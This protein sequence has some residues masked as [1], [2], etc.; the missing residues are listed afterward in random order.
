MTIPPILVRSVGLAVVFLFGACSQNL[1]WTINPDRSG[2]FTLSMQV[3]SLKMM[4]KAINPSAE[5]NADEAAVEGLRQ[6]I[7]GTAGIEIWADPSITDTKDFTTIAITGYFPDINKINIT[8]PLP[9]SP[10][11]VLDPNTSRMSE[12]GKEW[13]LTLS[14]SPVERPSSTK[15]ATPTMSNEEEADIRRET[16]EAQAQAE[17][18]MTL[19]AKMAEEMPK[20]MGDRQEIT[21]GGKILKAEG[22]ETDGTKAWVFESLRDKIQLIMKVLHDDDVMLMIIREAKRQGVGITNIDLRKLSPDSKEVQRNAIRR[23]FPAGVGP[24][25]LTILPGKPVFDYAK[26]VADARRSPNALMKRIRER[27]PNSSIAVDKLE[28]GTAIIGVQ[29]AES[30]QI[31]SVFADSPAARAGLKEGDRIMKVDGDDVKNGAEVSAKIRIRKP[32]DVVKLFVRR[33]EQTIEVKITLSAASEVEEF[34]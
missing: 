25:R 1:R 30:N 18:A 23:Y 8:M 15:R 2:K 17:M 26:E 31:A 12:D 29:F 11:P 19:F 24:V 32:G 21:P 7:H 10:N 34:K 20:E 28:P 27:R 9:G 13:V 14:D 16:R 33:G 22:C 4:A 3:P 6:M 5:A